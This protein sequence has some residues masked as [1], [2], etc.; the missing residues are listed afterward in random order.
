MSPFGGI[1]VEMGAKRQKVPPAE[2]QKILPESMVKL[3][4]EM[5]NSGN[6][7]GAIALIEG[8]IQKEKLLPTTE[9]KCR[10]LVSKWLIQVHVTYALFCGTR[11]KARTLPVVSV[12]DQHR[13]GPP[14]ARVRV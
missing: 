2:K 3:A 12:H 4:E 10:L 13:P 11:L 5:L 1:L 14:S 6:I 8:L 7:F 9:A